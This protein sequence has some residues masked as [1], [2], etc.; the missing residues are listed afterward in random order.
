MKMRICGESKC[1]KRVKP[2]GPPVL[3]GH[4]LDQI[5]VCDCGWHDVQ[6]EMLSDEEVSQYR[7]PKEVPK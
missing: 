3:Y 7:E 4:F 6:T 1:N 5:V 2:Y